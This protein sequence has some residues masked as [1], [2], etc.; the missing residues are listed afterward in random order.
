MA[1]KFV[2]ITISDRSYYGVREDQSGPSLCKLI[3]NQKWILIDRL[4]IPDDFEIIRETLMATCNNNEVDIVLTTG[5]TGFSPT[6][7][8]PEATLSVI[9]KIAP[10]LGEAMREKSLSITPHA[11]LSRAIA[12]ILHNKLVINLPGSPKAA[13]ENF[14]TILPV[15]PHAVEL[16]QDL[17]SSENGHILNNV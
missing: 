4:I 15:L 1:I 14:L 16:L 2:V 11:M 9:E 5:G 6:D 13:E 3:E 17:P 8:T 7:V 12:G 10:G